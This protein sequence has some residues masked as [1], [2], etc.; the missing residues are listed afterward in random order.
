MKIS[1]RT[2]TPLHIGGSTVLTPM[3]YFE[4]GDQLYVIGETRLSQVLAQNRLIDDFIAEMVRSGRNFSLTVYM[5]K[6][7][8][9]DRNA[10]EA[11]MLYK[12]TLLSDAPKE[13]RPFVRNAFAQPYIPGSA[14]KGALRTSILY[15]IFKSLPQHEKEKRL[16][17]P[18]ESQLSQIAKRKTEA[19]SQQKR[20]N[21]EREKKFFY[22]RLEAELFQGY[23]LPR[24]TVKTDPKFDLFRCLQVS[25]SAPF[26]AD[27]LVIFPIRIYSARSQSLKKPSIISAEC[28]PQ[29][30]TVEVEYAFDEKLWKEFCEESSKTHWGTPMKE[31]EPWLRNPWAC[32]QEMCRDV[33]D[34]EAPFFM[35]EFDTDEKFLNNADLRLGWGGGLLSTSLCLLLPDDL[36][37]KIRNLLFTDRGDAPAPKSRKI[38]DYNE[39]PHFSMG[40]LRI[41]KP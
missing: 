18:V 4:M 23:G 13:I 28:L 41:E 14:V 2:A 12:S 19:Q 1:L 33:L 39:R 5:K 10:A 38:I 35:D 31:F 3:D 34:H 8:L 40:W 29:Q 11:V 37:K 36:R 22:S 20:F 6:H 27:G 7:G 17:Q 9:L 30:R 26:D 32:Q 25:D 15:K 24:S 16:W 21:A